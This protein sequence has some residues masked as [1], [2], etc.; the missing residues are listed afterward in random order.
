LG[1]C[2]ID[3][4]KLQSELI[5]LLM[6]VVDQQLTE[7]S[8]SLKGI[9]LEATLNLCHEGKP[10]ILAGEIAIEVNRISRARGERPSY[11]AEVIGYRLKKVGLSTRRLG[12][13][14]KWLTMDL[15]TVTR[16]HELATVYGGVGLD[17]GDNLHCQ[18]CIENTQVMDVV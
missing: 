8:S 3:S 17:R 4:P 5:T 7:L 18:H 11:S 10:Q 12:K 13:A 14:G 16:I 6:P 15:A 9:T 2:I 1:A